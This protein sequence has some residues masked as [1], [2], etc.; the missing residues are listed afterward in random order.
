MSCP[1][2]G[3]AQEHVCVDNVAFCR[4]CGPQVW[5]GQDPRRPEG[6]AAQTHEVVA[7]VARPLPPS[8]S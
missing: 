4:V 1:A 2:C 8:R 6:A 7:V 5:G 3:S